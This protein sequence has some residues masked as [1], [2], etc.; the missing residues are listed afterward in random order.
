MSEQAKFCFNG[1]LILPVTPESFEVG[2]GIKVETVNIHALGDLRIAGYPTLDSINISGFL[3][4]R[5][6]SFAITDDVQPYALVAQF[7][8]WSA[9]RTVV[10]FLVTGTDVNLPVLVETIRYGERDGSG[11]VYYTLPLAEYRHVSASAALRRAVDRYP[12]TPQYYT[13]QKGENLFIISEKM[14]GDKNKAKN[15]AAVNGI[16]NMHSIRGGILNIPQ[17]K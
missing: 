10:R 11:D 13:P 17:V 4:A 15:I 1:S 16:K 7:K 9:R 3:P 12:M 6:Y 8:A 5:Q 14:Y 2:A